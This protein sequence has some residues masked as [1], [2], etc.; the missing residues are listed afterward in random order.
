MTISETYM[1]RALV[2]NPEIC[3]DLVFKRCPACCAE[4]IIWNKKKQH[5]SKCGFNLQKYIKQRKSN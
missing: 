5:C 3:E 4:Y 1:I 2:R